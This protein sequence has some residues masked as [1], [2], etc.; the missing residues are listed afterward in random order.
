MIKH[1]SDCNE[2]KSTELVDYSMEGNQK[3]YLITHY[4]DENNIILTLCKKQLNKFQEGA[5]C[6]RYLHFMIQVPLSSFDT[7]YMDYFKRVNS[8]L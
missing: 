1:I 3:N 5:W 4:E 2:G 6:N 7:S 8:F